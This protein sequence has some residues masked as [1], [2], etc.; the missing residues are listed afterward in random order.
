MFLGLLKMSGF[1]ILSLIYGKEK[2]KE[3]EES[4]GQELFVLLSV[5]LSGLFAFWMICLV[6]LFSGAASNDFLFALITA[7][8]FPVLIFIWAMIA[9]KQNSKEF[10]EKNV[11]QKEDTLDKVIIKDDFQVKCPN[12]GNVIWYKSTVVCEH[13]NFHVQ[14][15]FQQTK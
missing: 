8:A 1:L 10:K 7:I 14:E 2:C 15:Y 11:E 4:L 3:K 13:C 5:F 9:R 6:L 12:C